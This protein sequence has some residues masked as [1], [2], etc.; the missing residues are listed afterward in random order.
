MT[1]APVQ[2]STEPVPNTRPATPSPAR[3]APRRDARLAVRRLGRRPGRR[4]DPGGLPPV[5]PLRPLPAA[6]HPRRRVRRHRHPLAGREQPRPAVAADPVP[7]RRGVLAGLPRRR[8]AAGPPTRARRRDPLAG[9]R[10]GADTGGA[11]LRRAGHAGRAEPPGAGVHARAAG[12]V[13]PRRADPCVRR[14]RHRAARRRPA[15]ARHLAGVAEHLGRAE[16][17]DGAARDLRRW[18]GGRVGRPPCTPTGCR[19]S[20]RPGARSAPC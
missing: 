3:L 10:R 15:R 2:P 7:R 13:G 6:P 11:D 5:P 4:G 18:R 14:A 19:A 12:L 16:R 17:A 8:R 20:R 9:G 1:Q